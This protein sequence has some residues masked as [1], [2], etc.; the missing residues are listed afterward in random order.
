[1]TTEQ[2]LAL[3]YMRQVFGLADDVLFAPVTPEFVTTAKHEPGRRI[4]VAL[5]DKPGLVCL[6]FRPE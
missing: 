3:S 6:R 5:D 1:M 4:A 2:Y